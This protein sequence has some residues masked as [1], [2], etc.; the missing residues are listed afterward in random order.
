MVTKIELTVII[1]TAKVEI[2]FFHIFISSILA[3]FHLWFKVPSKKKNIFLK[4]TITYSGIFNTN[5]KLYDK[6]QY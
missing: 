3:N 4:Y 1:V 2:S 6:S 5:L